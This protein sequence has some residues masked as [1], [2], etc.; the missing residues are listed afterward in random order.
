LNLC[1]GWGRKA[2]WLLQVLAAHKPD[3]MVLNETGLFKEDEAE[4]DALFEDYVVLHNNETRD[5]ALR[6]KRFEVL[7]SVPLAERPQRIRQIWQENVNPRTHGISILVRAGIPC[8]KPLAPGG[9]PYEGATLNRLRDLLVVKVGSKARHQL[10]IVGAYS[11]ANNSAEQKL[12]FSWLADAVGVL[13]PSRHI[14]IAGDLNATATTTDA[15]N[16]ARVH[17]LGALLDRGYVCA[18]RQQL[19]KQRAY[20][21]PSKQDRNEGT[22]IDRMLV[23]QH[24]L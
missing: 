19:G 2:G 12:F 9:V 4:F 16:K 3:V 7:S 15:T 22:L 1:Q 13:E 10:T 20:S 8:A 21:R 5:E 6:R 18:I 17:T 23:S 24:K 14:I 11:P